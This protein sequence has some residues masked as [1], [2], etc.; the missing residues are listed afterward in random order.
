MWWR[1]R[2]RRRRTPTRWHLR[3]ESR[4]LRR[5]V[6]SVKRCGCQWGICILSEKTLCV[7]G[8]K[9]HLAYLWGV[10]SHLSTCFVQ[11][12]ISKSQSWKRL[13]GVCMFSVTSYRS[14]SAWTHSTTLIMES[15]AH[16]VPPFSRHCV[17]NDTPMIP[18]VR[19]CQSGQLWWIT[20]IVFHLL[21]LFQKRPPTHS[22]SYLFQSPLQMMLTATSSASPPHSG[23]EPGSPRVMSPV[24]VSDELSISTTP[25]VA[26]TPNGSIPSPGTGYSWSI[27]RGT[28]ILKV[29]TLSE[30]QKVLC[31]SFSV[32]NNTQ[33]TRYNNLE[34]KWWCSVPNHISPFLIPLSL[35]LWNNPSRREEWMEF[36]SF[37]LNPGAALAIEND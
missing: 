29:G 31:A 2:K 1:T 18:I 4:R 19:W 16:L 27:R 14:F 23:S 6:A 9:S 7:D 22:Q 8:R 10:V 37:V 33:L 15:A 36:R 13:K 21:T 5:W 17:T 34:L 28:F 24:N 30:T 11:F 12:Q 26:F 25:T 32:S 35:L 20:I 3:K